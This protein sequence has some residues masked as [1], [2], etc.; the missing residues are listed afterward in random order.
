VYARLVDDVHEVLALAINWTGKTRTQY[1]SWA[2]DNVFALMSYFP[3]VMKCAFM[4][5]VFNMGWSCLRLNRDF[6]LMVSRFW[7]DLEEVD[8]SSFCVRVVKK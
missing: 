5:Y 7:E 8:E 1:P 3:T 6:V 4:W 2:G